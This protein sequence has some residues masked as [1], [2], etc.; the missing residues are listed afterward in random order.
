MK[1]RCQ[2]EVAFSLGHEHK[3]QMLPPS[4]VSTFSSFN[5]PRFPLNLALLLPLHL[6]PPFSICPP[7]PYLSP[8][9]QSSASGNF[10]FRDERRPWNTWRCRL[11]SY[12]GTSGQQE[13]RQDPGRV[14]VFVCA[15]VCTGVGMSVR[16]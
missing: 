10:A 16:S 11:L 9:P 2:A 7:L 8:S 15:W 4:S 5:S 13:W 1:E 14:C 3:C 12:H 6:L